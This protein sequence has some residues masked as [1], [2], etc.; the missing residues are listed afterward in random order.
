MLYSSGTTGRPKGV[1]PPLPLNPVGTPDALYQLVA[2]LFGPDAN[3]VYLS[4]APLYHAAPLR[5]SLTMQR[6]GA[7]VVVMDRFDPEQALA[8]IETYRV[9]HS[10]WVPAHFIRMLKLPAEVRAK[11]DLS[12]LR[13]AVH[14]AAPC[15]I[16]VKE[17]MIEWWGPVLHEYYSGTELIAYCRDQLAHYKCPRSVDF[18]AE[19]PRLPTGKLLKRMLRDEYAR[20]YTQSEQE[21]SRCPLP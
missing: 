3:S 9:T 20:A 2:F 6:S 12:S 7:T 19:L 8:A 5:Y 18:R 10:Q 14:A 21:A 17:Q 13:Y 16:P 1:R 11:F 15:P 4:P